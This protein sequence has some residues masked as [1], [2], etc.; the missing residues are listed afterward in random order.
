MR[1]N[2]LKRW[3]LTKE[4]SA[5]IMGQFGRDV[6]GLRKE[7]EKLTAERDQEKERA[8]AA[9]KY[10]AEELAKR[11]FEDALKDAI[12]GCQFTSEAAKKA[13]MEEVREAGLK[14]MGGKILGLSD[15]LTQLKEKDPAAFV[16]EQQEQLETERAR[17]F[18]RPLNGGR[19]SERFF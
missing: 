9:E 5:K 11:D 19:P 17:P 8:Q 15:F 1:T 12:G 16:N 14:V 13:I 7:I 6:T 18:T 3:G 4:Q 10:Y 2:D